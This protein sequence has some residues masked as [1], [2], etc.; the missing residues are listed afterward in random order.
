MKELA[1]K[2]YNDLRFGQSVIINPLGSEK[3]CSYD[4]VYCDLGPSEVRMNQIKKEIEFPKVKDIELALRETLREANQQNIE[5]K[6]LLLSGNGEP[7]LYPEIPELIDRLLIVRQELCPSAKLI[8]LSN[9]AHLDTNKMVHALDQL[10]ERIIK[11]DC[12]NE[13]SFKKTN[14]PLIRA[15]LSRITSG[16]RKLK[17]CI[18]QSMFYGGPKTN[19]T[20]DNIDEWMELVGILKPKKIQI[21]TIDRPP[22]DPTCT[23][24]PE[25]DLYIIESRIKRKLDIPSEVFVKEP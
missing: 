23:P 6:S 10:D 25:D 8:L 14:S 4:C 11:L 17:D 15:T 7:T 16:S 12:G 1:G 5:I 22:V 3:L 9:G 19:N 18:V 24:L 13:R 2:P 21:Y 20:K